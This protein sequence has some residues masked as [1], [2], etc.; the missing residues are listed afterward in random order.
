MVC[1]RENEQAENT[2]FRK[3]SLCCHDK[4]LK[5]RIGPTHVLSHQFQAF[6]GGVAFEVLIIMMMVT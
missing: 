1:K 3:G 2:A 4:Y 6:L 5:V